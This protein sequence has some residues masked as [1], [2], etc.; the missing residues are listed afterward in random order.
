LK[1]KVISW[2]LPKRLQ[3]GLQRGFADKFTERLAGAKSLIEK[4]TMPKRL[5]NQRQSA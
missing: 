5:K 1:P 3:R 2:E 4:E